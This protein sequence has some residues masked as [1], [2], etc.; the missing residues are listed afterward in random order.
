MLFSEHNL[1]TTSYQVTKTC[2]ETA[3]N[4]LIT[5]TV[6]M[7][8][9]KIESTSLWKP[10]GTGIITHSSIT[11]RTKGKGADKLGRWAHHT[12]D[13]KDGRSITVVSCYQVCKKNW[14]K[15]GDMTAAAQQTSALREAGEADPCPR[16][17]F[18][19]DLAEFVTEC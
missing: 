9:S 3:K 11:S 14:T 4:L 8:S 2:E 5:P 13:G 15:P 16:K 12:M 17:A 7:A 1:D 19:R 18:C 6:T 10:G